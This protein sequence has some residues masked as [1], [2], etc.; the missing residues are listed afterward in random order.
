MASTLPGPQETDR[1]GWN[2][3]DNYR[4]VHENRLSRHTFLDPEKPHTVTFNFLRVGGD[5][6]IQIVGEIFCLGGIVVEV[7]KYLET[8]EAPSGQIFVRGFSYRYNAYLP[9]KHNLLRFD[10]GHSFDEY[11]RHEWDWATGKETERCIITRNEFPT[12]GE[13]L[14]ELERQYWQHVGR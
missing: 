8:Y 2:S 13:V 4:S 9:G 10:N 1:H 12:L 5:L 7:E 3:F 14:D 6:V 11:H